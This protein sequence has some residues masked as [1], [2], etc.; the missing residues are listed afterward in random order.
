MA[1]LWF[2]RP[3]TPTPCVQFSDK[4]NPKLLEIDERCEAALKEEE[5]KQQQAA[6]KKAK[7][8]MAKLNEQYNQVLF[9]LTYLLLSS[10]SLVSSRSMYSHTSSRRR[11]RASSL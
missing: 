1:P 8:L 10:R 4:Y 6:R 9:V 5:A 7:E 11:P 2:P 3:P